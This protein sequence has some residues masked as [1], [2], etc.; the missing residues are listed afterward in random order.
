[1][2]NS[3]NKYLTKIKIDLTDFTG[4][5]H[6]ITLREP[7]MAEWKELMTIQKNLQKASD[8]VEKIEAIIPFG[9][10]LCTLIVDNDFY[11]GEGVDK[12][13]MPA[14][15]LA[16]FASSKLD[17]QMHILGEYIKQLPLA[18]QSGKK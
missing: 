4:D 1:M 7:N 6:Y 16:E 10:V 18:S 11:E 5:S 17:M 15:D 3:L 9:D 13:A 14:K 2:H 12:K 8:D